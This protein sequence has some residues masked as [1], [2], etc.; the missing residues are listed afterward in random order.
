M[1]QPPPLVATGPNGPTSAQGWPSTPYFSLI[2]TLSPS[3][4]P[5]QGTKVQV[6]LHPIAVQYNTE[7]LS[8]PYGR[9]DRRSRFWG[10]NTHR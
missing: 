6:I 1:A 3:S 9:L 7:R 4:T 2:K 5:L 10:P 8:I